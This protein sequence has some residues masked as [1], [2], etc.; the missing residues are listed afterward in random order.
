MEDR[1]ILISKEPTCTCSLQIR[2][3][4]PI[5]QCKGM[6]IVREKSITFRPVNTF[7]GSADFIFVYDEIHSARLVKSS[8]DGS[9]CLLLEVFAE[10]TIR[11]SKYTFQIPTNTRSDAELALQVAKSCYIFSRAKDLLD[12]LTNCVYVLATKHKVPTL[13]LHEC[14]MYEERVVQS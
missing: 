10:R 7:F 14:T 2:P 6:L 9:D 12:D 4:N 1:M 3:S 5:A 11:N 8:H 13:R